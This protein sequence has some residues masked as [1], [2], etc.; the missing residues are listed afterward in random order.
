VRCLPR[1]TAALS[2]PVPQAFVRDVGDNI[3]P[4]WR[5]IAARR[6]ALPFT[7]EQRQWQLLRCAAQGGRAAALACFH[8]RRRI[9]NLAH[10]AATEPQAHPRGPPS[11]AGPTS[12]AL[13]SPMSLLIAALHRVSPAPPEPTSPP[14]PVAAS[15]PPPRRGRYLEFNLLYDRGVKFGLDG[16][17]VESIM[18]SAPPLI[19]W[20]YNV[21][22]TEGSAE[23]ALL[24]VLRQPREWT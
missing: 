18:V 1:L 13:S 21:Q 19:A 24:D 4:S 11:R 15:P 16:G 10:Y 8:R 2:P 12:R 14:C 9:L 7:E 22:P 5:A 3:L 20:K 23:G 17:R 6:R